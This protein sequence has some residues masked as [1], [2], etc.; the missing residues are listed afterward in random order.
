MRGA[1]GGAAWVG[2]G[3]ARPAVFW[4]ISANRW[5]IVFI[6]SF[7]RPSSISKKES[8]VLELGSLLALGCCSVAVPCLGNRCGYFEL[9]LRVRFTCHILHS[10]LR[11]YL[12]SIEDGHVLG[13]NLSQD[14]PFEQPWG[15]L[16]PLFISL[17]HRDGWALLHPLPDMP[18]RHW[19]RR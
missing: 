9:F 2:W 7:I 1:A 16:L 19:P 8:W 5:S 11:H 18:Y 17:R 3:A 6:S 4:W 10:S 14:F 12:S 15:C 13:W